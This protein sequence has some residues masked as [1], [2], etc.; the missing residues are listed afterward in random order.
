M[1]NVSCSFVIYT[2]KTVYVTS[3]SRLF[4]F[5]LVLILVVLSLI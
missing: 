5:D 4:L 1:D 2:V 3:L